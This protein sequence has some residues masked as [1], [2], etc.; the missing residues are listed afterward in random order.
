MVLSYFARLS[1]FLYP[2]S[3]VVLVGAAAFFVAIG[4]WEGAA[5][6]VMFG[7]LN[8]FKHLFEQGWIRS[9]EERDDREWLQRHPEEEPRHNGSDRA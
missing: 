7:V 3:W 1:S 6:V 4:R 8:W 5:A 2:M 9:D